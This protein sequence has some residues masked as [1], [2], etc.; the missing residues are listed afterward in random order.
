MS[1]PS[2]RT[3]RFEA[4]FRQATGNSAALP[5]QKR[6]ALGDAFPTL[7]D[8]PTG[9]GKTAAAVLAWVWRR[10]FA[11]ESTH[12]TT[13][14]RLVYCLPMR[15]LVEQTF[16]ESVKW[17]DRLG[18]LAG[19]VEWTETDAA[20]L[21]TKKAQLKRPTDGEGRGYR[22]EFEAKRSNGWASE[23]GDGGQQPVAVH[24]LLGGEEKTD[25]ALRPERDAILI[26]TQDMLLSRA[27]NRG[28]AAG[29]ARWPLEFGFLNSDCLW[30]FDEIQIMDTGLASSLQFDAWRRCLRLRPARDQFLEENQNHLSRPCHSLWMSATMAKHWLERAVDWS[31]RVEEAWNTRHQLSET[32]QTDE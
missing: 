8:V 29:R 1:I 17:L 3:E 23:N 9:L 15:V 19:S 7:L 6:L 10:R 2:N 4:L 30:V 13:P 22:P 14:R 25:W 27:M 28:Y 24:L 21:P 32:E 16:T 26:G 11:E 31:P 20:D 5:Y 12:K 18:L